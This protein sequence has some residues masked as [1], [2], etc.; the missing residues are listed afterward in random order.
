MTAD[1]V[2]STLTAAGSGL[3]F[4]GVKVSIQPSDRTISERI[5]LVES[6]LAA[7]GTR[8]LA[9]IFALEC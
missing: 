2:R 9:P 4:E 7:L 1:H 8:R 5:A 6:A 3:I